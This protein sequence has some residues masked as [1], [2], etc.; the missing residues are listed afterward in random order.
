MEGFHFGKYTI[1][2]RI[3]ILDSF[4]DYFKNKT[5]NSDN[6]ILVLKYIEENKYLLIN[7]IKVELSKNQNEYLKLVLDL[8]ILSLKVPFEDLAI[9]FDRNFNDLG[10]DK[11]K[12]EVK[13][14][15]NTFNE[16]NK[17]INL[18]TQI[19]KLFITTV[20]DIMIQFRI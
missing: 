1:G 5:S 18:K 20:D 15:Y 2:F 16:L 19:D 8:D 7:G 13:R 14:Y 4:Y 11:K 9:E 12:K 3:E 17:K 6:N 10:E